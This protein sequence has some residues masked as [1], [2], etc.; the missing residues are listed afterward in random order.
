MAPVEQIG[1]FKTDKWG[2][3]KES[4]MALCR[5]IS[6]SFHPLQ[7]PRLPERGD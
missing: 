2:D 3:S 7:G 6:G 4:S 5:Q 1:F